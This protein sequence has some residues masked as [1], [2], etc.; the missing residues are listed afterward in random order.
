MEG[1]CPACGSKIDKYDINDYFR[2]TSCGNLLT[3]T[4]QDQIILISDMTTLTKE[5]IDELLKDKLPDSEIA[6]LDLAMIKHASALPLLVEAYEKFTNSE[7]EF[8]N[9]TLID[10]TLLGCIEN[11]DDPGAG[12]FLIEALNS[13]DDF[14][15]SAVCSAI[16]NLQY[17][18]A[19]ETLVKKVKDKNQGMRSSAVSALGGLYNKAAVQTL[20][21]CLS[22]DDY[23]VRKFALYA[24]D[25][26]GDVNCQSEIL[27]L[28]TLEI[29][30]TTRDYEKLLPVKEL[31][32]SVLG[33]LGNREI[34]KS[35]NKMT[36]DFHTGIQNAATEAV[37]KIKN[38][39]PHPLSLSNIIF[40]FLGLFGVAR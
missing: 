20:L 25:K 27:K 14:V 12:P 23:Y 29:N 6:A 18:P 31:A 34:L 13:K 37:R 33:N 16:E 10:E 36:L 32:I 30:K 9:Y 19:L 17:E 40:A 26:I 4:Q 2:C 38:R 35:I 24:L 39:H 7:H 11:I 1:Q 15:F 28:A 8:K 3:H 22:D 5:K 21:E